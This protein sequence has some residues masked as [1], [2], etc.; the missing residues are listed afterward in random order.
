[1]CQTA[2]ANAGTRERANVVSHPFYVRAVARVDA[3]LVAGANKQRHIDRQT[4]F[5]LSRFVAARGRVTLDARLSVRHTQLHAGREIDAEGLIV[6]VATDAHSGD[7]LMVA[8][9]NAEAL[10]K[11][12]ATGEAW[13][14]SRSRRALWR[15]GEQS[16]QKQRLVELRLDC[17]GD[18]LLLLV[19]QTG[20][21]CHT[22]R[23]SC[24]FRAWRDG[25]WTV[26]AEP[27]VDPQAL[28]P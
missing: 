4:G 17:D 12:I 26:I 21:A 3:D 11:T 14:F 25:A 7:V 10:A 24:F 13:Y 27:E 16:G 9:M 2:V 23:R 5:E 18:S 1:M 28:Y 6:C 20:V 19:E 22:G 15:K 8:H